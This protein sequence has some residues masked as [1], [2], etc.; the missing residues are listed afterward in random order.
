[1]IQNQSTLPLSIIKLLCMHMY[2][3]HD[4]VVVKLLKEW[5]CSALTG[6]RPVEVLPAG[7]QYIP[8]YL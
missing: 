4:L 1:M 5:R 3:L 8:M 2:T 7:T 6:S